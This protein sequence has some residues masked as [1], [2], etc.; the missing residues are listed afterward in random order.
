VAA[1]FRNRI[2]ECSSVASDA[3]VFFKSSHFES[4]RIIS[5]SA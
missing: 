1:N 3:H 4:E 2:C 5:Y